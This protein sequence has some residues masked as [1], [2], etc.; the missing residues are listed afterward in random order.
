VAT[1]Q[2]N[3]MK[4]F[5][6]LLLATLS[7][8]F[9]TAH[10]GRYMLLPIDYIYDGDTIKTHIAERRLPA[11]LNKLSIR[12]NGIDTPEMPAKSYATTN[13]LGRA[14][15]VKEAEAAIEAKNAVMYLA[16]DST[17]MKITNF[18]WGKFGSRIVADVTI[19]G[20]DVASYLIELQ[21]AIPY[22][23]KAKTKDWCL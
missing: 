12:V 22:Y 8:S 15:C 9:V 18:K 1:K 13:K 16:K 23:G 20:T 14:K 4:L 10:A 19:N 17:K 7:L 2:E 6:G 3:I 21:L 11:P 5:I